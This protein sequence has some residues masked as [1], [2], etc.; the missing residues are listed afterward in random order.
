MGEFFYTNGKLI[1]EGDSIQ[2]SGNKGI[3]ESL[4]G[5]GTKKSKDFCCFVTGGIMIRFKNGDLQVWPT[6]NEDLIFLNRKKH[7]RLREYLGCIASISSFS[8]SVFMNWR[9][10]E[11][12]ADVISGR[13]I[14][15]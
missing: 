4:I 12:F 2:V 11:V 9:N 10:D 14:R 3:I 13:G 15:Q 1:A 6:A 7:Q 5:K 8:V